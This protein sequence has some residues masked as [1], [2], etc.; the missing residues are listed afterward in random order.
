MVT[1]KQ[2]SCNATANKVSTTDGNAA[3]VVLPGSGLGVCVAVAGLAA[4]I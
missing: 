2:A 1:P 4:M 3:A